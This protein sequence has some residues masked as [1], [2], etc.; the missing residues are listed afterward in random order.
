M[1]I[2]VFETPFKRNEI[3]VGPSFKAGAF[4]S[5]ATDCP[6][7]FRHGE[8]FLMTFVGWD[9]V[10]YR[11]GIA[12]SP[13]LHSWEKQGLLIDRGVPGSATEFNVAMTSIMRDNALFGSS[14]L[15]PVDGRFVGTYHAYPGSGYEVGPGVIGL[16]FSNDLKN[17]EVG[18]P[19]LRPG[20]PGEWD[21]GGL[22]KSWLM[23]VEGTFY[24]FYNA[25]N[26]DRRGWIEQTGFATSNDLVNWEKSPKNPV[27]PNGPAG[28]FD[29]LFASDPC[30]LWDGNRWVMFYFGNSTDGHARDG[31]AF[32]QNLIQWEKAIELLI[33]VGSPGS[34]DDKYAHKPAMITNGDVLFHF[35]NAVTQF[36]SRPMGEIDHTEI[37]GITYATNVE[38]AN[39]ETKN[40][41]IMISTYLKRVL[42][43]DLATL[44]SQI[45]AYPED[46]QL[47][48]TAD[49][50][51][52]SGGTLA[53]HLIGNLRHFIG[54]KLGGSGFVRDRDAEFNG[55][56]IPR[57]EIAETINLA[58]EEVSRALDQVTDEKLD[59]E[60]PLAFGVV[61]LTN[62]QFLTHLVAH[63][64][65]HLGQLDYHRRLTTGANESVGVSQIAALAS[66]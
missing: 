64:S 22:Y 33:D 54:A 14:T 49:G 13:D 20:L 53:L 65:Y 10:G 63:F 19:V 35:Y 41:P 62:G 12:S 50:I 30:V 52:N 25:K 29:D 39:H 66:D 24:L 2:Q 36:E 5:H 60:Y 58:I 21:A 51:T 7:V 1:P 18:E 11:T 37:R 48:S 23:E 61:Q 32:S 3:V 55:R 46:G 47:W 34:I 28:S 42:V 38:L 9:G 4:D 43:R 17:W 45:D 26:H 44:K 8:E 40:E 16:C 27:L 56:N 31:V 57:V 15:K 6:F 59:D